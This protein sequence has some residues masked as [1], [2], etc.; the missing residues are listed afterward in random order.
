MN[1][2]DFLEALDR[3]TR[4]SPS[5]EVSTGYEMHQLAWQEEVAAP[6][7]LSAAPWTGQLVDLGYVEPDAALGGGP[8]PPPRRVSWSDRELQSFT[9]YRV[10]AAGRQ[11][12]ERLRR[13][14]REQLSDLA[15]GR[16]LIP[17][18]RSRGGAAAQAIDRPLRDLRAALDDERPAAA[19]GA[20]KDL[21]EAACKVVLAR[22]G[23]TGDGRGSLPALF[24]QARRAAGISDGDLGRSL[25][26]TVQRLAE[27]R[28]A[29]GAG[30]GRVGG[31]DV[32]MAE[33]R[34]AA[35]SASGLTAFLLSREVTPC[36]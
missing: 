4:A 32:T 26:A 24:T 16:T 28:N 19:V 29:A 6:G 21:V 1:H 35:T 13:A 14:R 27:L 3:R 10:T 18:P 8:Q 5:G 23:R 12:A 15:L 9:A 25:A 31:P 36:G 33:A 20:A 11:E 17:A 22:S 34:L 7:E 2:L 30:H